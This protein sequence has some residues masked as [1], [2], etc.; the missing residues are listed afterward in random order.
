MRIENF[1][2]LAAAI[3]ASKDSEIVGR[4]RLQKTIWFLQR[5]GLPTEYGYKTHFYG[6]YSEDLQAE[7]EVLES[8]G[9]VEEKQDFSTAR[10]STFYR[11]KVVRQDDLPIS[12]LPEK[13]RK[14]LPVLEDADPVVLELAATYD[15][16]R[17]QGSEHGEAL[18]R[19]KRKKGEKCEG[20][21]LDKALDLVKKLGLKAA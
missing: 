12:Q 3:A 19:V 11:T 1:R 10:H 7:V 4:T 9:I 16:F 6:P 18:D 13:V 15:A 20:G 17:D 5:L 14:A 8:L 2:W 21:N